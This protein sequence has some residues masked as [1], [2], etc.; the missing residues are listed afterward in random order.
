MSGPEIFTPELALQLWY[1]A[2]DHEFGLVIELKPE[3]VETFKS[4]FWQARKEAGDPRLQ[5]LILHIAED[6]KTFTIKPR[7]HNALP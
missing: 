7:L 1:E 2:L 5:S 3:D 4:I 6:K